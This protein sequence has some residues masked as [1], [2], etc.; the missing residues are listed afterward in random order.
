MYRNWDPRND[1]LRDSGDWGRVL[2]QA[3]LSGDR[4]AFVALHTARL[5]GG[6]LFFRGDGYLLEPAGVDIRPVRVAVERVLEICAR[7]R[8]LERGV[9][10]AESGTGRNSQ[11]NINQR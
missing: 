2:M 11:E 6:R 4:D 10:D 3:N 7:L 5:R 1:L 9:E 8:K